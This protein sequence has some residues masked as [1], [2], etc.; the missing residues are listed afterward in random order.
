MISV[1]Q[2]NGGQTD[3][4]EV[5][6]LLTGSRHAENNIREALERTGLKNA[7]ITE[8]FEDLVYAFF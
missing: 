5:M 2:L 1:C 3:L 7:L 4:S 8:E 6:H